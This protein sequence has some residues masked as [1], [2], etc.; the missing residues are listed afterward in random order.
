MPSMRWVAVCQWCGKRGQITS[1]TNGRMP[2]HNPS[3]PGKCTSH[4]SGNKNMDHGA[5]WV[6]G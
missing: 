6:Q 5:Q 4:P 1:T 2:G 3:V